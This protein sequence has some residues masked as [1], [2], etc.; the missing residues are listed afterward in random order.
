[1]EKRYV[2]LI[3]VFLLVLVVILVVIIP[4]I[5]KT[6]SINSVEI[7]LGKSFTLIKGQVAEYRTSKE[8]LAVTL[9]NEKNIQFEAGSEV[10]VDLLL[11]LRRGK[12]TLTHTSTLSAPPGASLDIWQGYQ[13]SL[14]DAHVPLT[15]EGKVFAT[16]VIVENNDNKKESLINTNKNEVGSRSAKEP[17][18]NLL[19]YN[20]YKEGNYEKAS[21]LFLKAIEAN[22]EHAVAHYNYASTRAILRRLR[23]CDFGWEEIFE[24]LLEAVRIDPKRK[25][26]AVADPDL[27][28]FKNTVLINLWRGAGYQTDRQLE[29][30]LPDVRWHGS[31]HGEGSASGCSEIV[32]HKDGRVE[33]AEPLLPP[34]T[35][36]TY[37]VKDRVVVI[38]YEAE[39]GAERGKTS[40]FKL[41][42]EFDGTTAYLKQ[43]DLLLFDE[44]P[45]NCNV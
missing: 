44:F 25:L 10:R 16:F 19:G 7:T 5:K 28:E 21:D 41:K 1:M 4:M 14:Q 43:G 38:D 20:E 2:Y 39:V 32:F 12:E 18:Y 8:T 6:P 15:D 24:H 40:S 13:F 35:H 22:P 23:P 31:C 3:L 34:A 27:S 11:E 37:R 9:T 17:N 45:D 33:F 30:L 26:K 42:F 29:K 36:G